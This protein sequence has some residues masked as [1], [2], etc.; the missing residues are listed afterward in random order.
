MTDYDKCCIVGMLGMVNVWQIAE[1]MSWQK[2]F[3]E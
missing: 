2:R 1:V 3:D